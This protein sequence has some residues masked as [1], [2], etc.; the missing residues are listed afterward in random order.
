M[1]ASVRNLMA[2][3]AAATAFVASAVAGPFEDGVAAY[4][5]RFYAKAA[6]FWQPLADKGDAAAQYRLGA[7]YADGKGVERNDATAFMWFRRAAEQGDAAAQYDVGSSYFSGTGVPKND[8]E[9]AKWFL[10][11]ANQGMEFAQLNLGLL[12]AAGNGVPQDNV[13]AFK[14][15]ELAFFALPAGGARSDVARAMTDVAEH[16]TKEQIADAKQRE[17]GWKAKPEV[18]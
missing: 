5:E 7:L 6:E 10:R 2:V 17:R 14:W 16:M 8:V 3:I 9:A 1:K 4:N 12:Y 15:L 18:K 11:A 13:E